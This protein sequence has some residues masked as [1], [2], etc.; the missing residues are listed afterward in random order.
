MLIK[1]LKE[2]GLVLLLSSRERR[3]ALDKFTQKL[4]LTNS[5]EIILKMDCPHHNNRHAYKGSNNKTSNNA[6]ES[7]YRQ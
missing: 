7:N 5:T 1:T 6:V 2:N 4:L 3:S